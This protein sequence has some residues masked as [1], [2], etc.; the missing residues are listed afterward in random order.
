MKISAPPRANG[1]CGLHD[2]DPH[3]RPSAS[4]REAPPPRPRAGRPAACRSSIRRSAA[5]LNERWS[6]ASGST[7]QRIAFRST[8]LTGRSDPAAH[9]RTEPQRAIGG[10]RP[11]PLGLGARR[12]TVGRVAVTATRDRRPIG[13]P[14]R[15]ATRRALRRRPARSGSRPL[16]TLQERRFPG[17]HRT[18]G[19]SSPRCRMPP[20]ARRPL[21]AHARPGDL[22]R[23]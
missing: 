20:R 8:A 19:H 21:S 18:S 5:A 16:K 13:A 6:Y 22:G 15:A 3:C 1:T 7:Y 23:Q 2:G 12:A 9:A 17:S 14:P 10:D 4:R 11:Q